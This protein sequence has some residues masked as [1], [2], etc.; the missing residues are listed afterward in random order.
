MA[1]RHLAIGSLALLMTMAAG[2][3]VSRLPVSSPRSNLTP[4]GA[5]LYVIG[6]RSAEQRRSGSA[7]KLDSVLADLSRH[8][9]LARPGHVLADLHA[10]NPAARFV[11]KER[12]P[13]LWS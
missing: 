5:R 7:D 13:R 9:S 6:S 10:L 1:S 11:Q 2:A 12:A 8:A 3:A 4:G